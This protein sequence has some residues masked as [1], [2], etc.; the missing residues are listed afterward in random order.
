MTTLKAPRLPSS[1][2]F[3]T[4]K[5]LIRQTWSNSFMLSLDRKLFLVLSSLKRELPVSSIPGL[6]ECCRKNEMTDHLKG[7]YLK[8]T[9]KWKWAQKTRSFE[10]TSL[11]MRRLELKA[12]HWLAS[13]DSCSFT[14]STLVLKGFEVACVTRDG[15]PL[16]WSPHDSHERLVPPKSIC[17]RSLNSIYITKL[18]FFFLWSFFLDSRN[19]R[20]PFFSLPAL[21]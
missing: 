17:M 19:G 20:S 11:Q 1:K 21:P 5:S 2:K 14:Y 7:K 13:Q 8:L 9:S 15:G 6:R 10:H 4:K 3:P 16:A 18:G 12:T